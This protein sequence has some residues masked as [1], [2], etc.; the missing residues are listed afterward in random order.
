MSVSLGVDGPLLLGAALLLVAVVVTAV[1]VGAGRRLRMPTALILLGLGMLFG[2]DGLNLVSLS[3]PRLVQDLGVV[4]LLF[5]LLEGGLTTKPTDLRLAAL[6]GMLLSTLGVLITAAITGLGVWL[7]VD[8]EPVTAALI[9][10]VVASTDAAAVFSMMRTTTRPVGRATTPCPTGRPT[11][12]TPTPKGLARPCASA[13]CALRSFPAW[14]PV[15]T[16]WW[17]RTWPARRP[18]DPANRH[19]VERVGTWRP[20]VSPRGV[21]TDWAGSGR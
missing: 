21:A 13:R 16:R 19:C 6:P 12:A 5:I 1:M 7:F 11:E 3:D 10:A 4:A 14:T 17:P 20:G 8:V 15:E 18:D 2:D 9:G